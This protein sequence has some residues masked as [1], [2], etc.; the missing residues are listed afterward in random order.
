M[1]NP[2]ITTCP[3]I[4]TPQVS[5]SFY[6]SPNHKLWRPKLRQLRHRQFV[7]LHAIVQVAEIQKGAAKTAL[8]FHHTHATPC[9]CAEPCWQD[10]C[11][12]LTPAATNFSL[13][14]VHS[15]SF[16]QN[17]KEHVLSLAA[18]AVFA[19]CLLLSSL[20][21]LM[22]LL[23]YCCYCSCCWYIFAPCTVNTTNIKK[24]CL[25]PT[26]TC[27][28]KILMALLNANCTYSKDIMEKDIAG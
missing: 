7:Q 27:N 4:T 20:L 2:T 26:W 15:T 22:L 5:S 23:C 11:T 3:H 10:L 1:L 13:H 17:Q 16:R 24:A 25:S 18:L 8:S 6:I 14:N 12:E 9:E 21:L 28:R 19:V